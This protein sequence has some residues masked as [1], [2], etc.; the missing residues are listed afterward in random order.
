MPFDSAESRTSLKARPQTSLFDSFCFLNCLACLILFSAIAPHLCEAQEREESSKRFLRWMV[1]DPVAVMGDLDA[2]HFFMAGA[3]GIGIS[4]LSSYDQSS[5]RFFQRRYRNSG[6]LGV[7]N[8]LG[9]INLAAPLSALLFGTSLIT[10][11]LKFQDAAFTS[12]QAVLNTHL[13]V[14]LAKYAF[15]RERPYQHPTPYRFNL[16]EQ[17]ATSFPSGHTA[18]AF[19][20]VTPWVVYYPNAF[21][22]SLLALPLSTGIARVARGRHWL[23][24]ITAGAMIGAWWGYTLSKRHLNITEQN[25]VNIYPVLSDE[26]KGVS[27]SVSF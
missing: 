5:S 11:D 17:G 19:A 6:Y 1:N 24:D 10:D 15:G 9:N 16:F 7:T 8:E 12:F 2:E 25:N 4:A 27:V 20:L 3:T 23:T 14:G 18:T 13:T 21:T 22:Y 26:V